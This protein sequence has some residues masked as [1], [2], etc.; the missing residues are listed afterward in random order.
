MNVFSVVC[1]QASHLSWSVSSVGA[2]TQ[3]VIQGLTG[4][5]YWEQEA[6]SCRIWERISNSCKKR[7]KKKQNTLHGSK[8]RKINTTMQKHEEDTYSS[9]LLKVN[10][11]SLQRGKQP[12][13]ALN[14]LS[15]SIICHLGVGIGAVTCAHL[16]RVSQCR[17]QHHEHG[18]V[19]T[20]IWHHTATQTLT[21]QIK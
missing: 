2:C 9:V 8:H 1:R 4:R 18:Q 13:L 7:Q 10:K 12:M 11:S 14:T 20:E 17:V 16:N 3:E 15:Q 21:T 19:S 5:L 6:W